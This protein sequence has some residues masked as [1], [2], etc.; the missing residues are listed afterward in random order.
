MPKHEAIGKLRSVSARGKNLARLIDGFICIQWQADFFALLIS[1]RLAGAGADKW[2]SLTEQDAR[3]ANKSGF[4]AKRR[5][6]F[7]LDIKRY[8]RDY[9]YR[10]ANTR[11]AKIFRRFYPGKI[12]CDGRKESVLFSFHARR[13]N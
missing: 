2:A 12:D 3:R 13:A 6:R 11:E 9:F 8:V 1:L 7:V 4:K 10:D 5:S